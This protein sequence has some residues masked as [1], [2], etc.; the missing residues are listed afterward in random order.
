MIIIYS[1]KD[2]IINLRIILNVNNI[3]IIELHKT[4]L[5]IIH[6]KGKKRTI[7]VAFIVEYQPPQE[8]M[9]L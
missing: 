5:P 2:H 9:F 7:K 4:L 8:N 1:N 3:I 6:N